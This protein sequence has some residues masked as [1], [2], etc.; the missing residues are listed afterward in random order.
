MHLQNGGSGVDWNLDLVQRACLRSRCYGH[1]S[2]TGRNSEIKT[3]RYRALAQRAARNLRPQ[4][5]DDLGVWR[6]WMQVEDQMEMFK[7]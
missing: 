3:D 2:A 4:A 1:V 5:K 6:R 7:V